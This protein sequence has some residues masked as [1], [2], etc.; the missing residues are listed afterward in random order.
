MTQSRQHTER[1]TTRS[2]KKSREYSIL[3]VAVARPA[4][5]ARGLQLLWHC[6][7]L[8]AR[9]LR[10]RH[11][12]EQK[13][14]TLKGELGICKQKAGEAL[15]RLEVLQA[16]T[17]FAEDDRSDTGTQTEKE[18]DIFEDISLQLHGKSGRMKCQMSSL[19]VSLA[20]Q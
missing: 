19:T 1:K 2:P 8:L 11:A 16:T 6:F 7:Q 10:L 13:V 5:Y 12:A 4:L 15:Q 14:A 17:L 18:E 3:D 9:Q 20:T